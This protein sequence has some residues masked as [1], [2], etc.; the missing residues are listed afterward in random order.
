MLPL[1]QN[2]VQSAIEFMATSYSSDQPTPKPV[3]THETLSRITQVLTS[4]PSS[5]LFEEYFRR[6][7]PQFMAILDDSTKPE[8]SQI[9]AHIIMAGIL[10]KRQTGSPGSIGWNLFVK[11]L[12]EIFQPTLPA[13]PR[14]DTVLVTANDITLGIKRLSALVLSTPSPSLTGRLIKPILLPLWGLSAYD[15]SRI[16]GPELKEMASSIIRIFLKRSSTA[17]HF[18]DLSRNIFWDGTSDWKYGP[19][20]T[21]GIEIRV[22]NTQAITETTKDTLLKLEKRVSSF[23]ALLTD[24][25]IDGKKL[26]EVF[27]ALVN[28]S[29]ST[30]TNDI[31]ILQTIGHETDPL[32]ELGRT[33]IAQGL[34]QSHSKV[35]SEH[36]EDMIGFL[37]TVFVEAIAT[38]SQKASKSEN[39]SKLTL[40]DLASIRH[41][42]NTTDSGLP[43][44]ETLESQDLLTTSISLLNIILSTSSTKIINSPNVQSITQSLKNLSRIRLPPS[45]QS[46]VQI[47]LGL[48][49]HPQLVERSDLPPNLPTLQS[50]NSSLTSDIA[51]ERVRAL[52]TLNTLIATSTA[53]LDIPTAL[54]MLLHILRTDQDS[55]VFTSAISSIC[56]LAYERDAPY[57]VRAS[58]VAF[59]DVREATGVDGRLRVGEALVQLVQ[60][61][62]EPPPRELIGHSSSSL[63][64]TW[65]SL[66]STCIAVASR[67]GKRTR[68]GQERKRAE[69]LER[70]KRKEAERAWG[71]QVP[72]L[73]TFEDSSEDEADERTRMWK[74]RDSRLVQSVLEDWTNTGVEEDVRIRTSALSVTGEV[75]ERAGK[76]LTAGVVGDVMEVGLAILHTELSDGKAILR[77]AAVYLFMSH[78]RAVEKNG[79]NMPQLAGLQWVEVEKALKLVQ[80]VD[81]DDV[82]RGHASAV[83]E[84]LD[85][86]R[87]Q[88]ILEHSRPKESMDLGGQIKGLE[89]APET[90]KSSKI[91]EIE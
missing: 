54:H 45:I 65:R 91:Q 41:N 20:S 50:I 31:E 67:R 18:L 53:S 43:S 49:S 37:N 56:T 58:S 57:V 86:W 73:P 1:Q 29:F 14:L 72:S 23:L 87:M 77:R 44:Q 25:T 71:G 62:T 40:K 79:V 66:A 82:T 55:F 33:K 16:T 24:D 38:E 75:L 12:H 69:R 46:S 19:G 6:I 76:A 52:T 60:R 84:S 88:Q 51:P 28:P 17:T 81:R 32:Q 42:G 21:G 11:P 10:S 22:R 3:I 61:L 80:Q 89:I 2:G 39:A 78:L 5:L 30:A 9:V 68:E 36:P 47:A 27:I 15:E 34:L 64:E 4:I 90:T 83:I 63:N 26:T 8:M 70:M 13:N 35:L 48:L 7:S 85:A 59:Q 74:D